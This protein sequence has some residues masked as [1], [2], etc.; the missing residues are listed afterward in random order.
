MSTSKPEQP[1][2]LDSLIDGSYIP[3]S[4]GGS[5]SVP[6]PL[7]PAM[8]SSTPTA[9]AAPPKGPTLGTEEQLQAPAQNAESEPASGGSWSADGKT[10]TLPPDQLH[11]AEHVG[12]LKTIGR[13]AS[14][15]FGLSDPNS[16][17]Q[18]ALGARIGALAGRTGNALAEAAGTPEQKQL[19]EERTQMPLKLAQIQNERE[20]RQGILGNK[21]V[22]SGIHQQR[23]N[24]ADQMADVAQQNADS[25]ENL[26]RKQ[27]EEIDAKMNGEVIVTPEAANAAGDPSLANKRLKTLEYQQ[28]VTNPINNQLKAA[29]G[30][31]TVDLGADGV[32]GYNP[33]LGRTQRLGDSPAVARS[34]SML[35]RTQ[36]PVNDAQGNTLGWVNPQTNS[37]TPVGSINT[38]GGGAPLSASLGGDVVPP[39]PTS[40]ML[41]RGQVAQT[42]LPQ[43]P[44][45]KQEVAAL[46]DKI[47]PGAGRWNDFWVNKG[48]INDPE[49]AGL[50]QDLQLYATA[51]GMA[52]FGA[53]MPEGF[54]KDMMRDFGTAQ[55][56]EDLLSRIDH[57]EGW[58]RGYAQRVGGGNSPV[59]K[60]GTTVPSSSTPPPS[61]KEVSLAAA[62][63]LPIN[64]GKSETDVRADIVAHGHKVGK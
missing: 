42:I 8:S 64:K 41:S 60:K 45:M 49:Y 31:K 39:K 12:I 56:P 24:T 37:F 58:V 26:K 46:S 34:N 13:L 18:A 25:A 22:E 17:P 32:W 5:P 44:V 29:G 21:A 47:G 9:I 14:G 15:A 61:G 27:M 36:L 63:A 53:S 7:L 62:M 59:P 52:H 23:A 2:I 50:N 11:P 6:T 1:S 16:S 28:R 3:L 19:A 30:T 57:A 4:E 51:L 10:L 38:K 20:Y 54:V 48:G 35:L 55:S 40:S 33:L 43:I